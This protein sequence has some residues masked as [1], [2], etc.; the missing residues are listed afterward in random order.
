M[1]QNGG[2]TS[3]VSIAGG[4]FGGFFGGVVLTSIIAVLILVLIM[5]STKKRI[6]GKENKNDHIYT[7]TDVDLQ[8]N[9]AYDSTMTRTNSEREIVYEKCV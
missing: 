2:R 1:P 9:P 5:R 4:V 8:Q 3:G 7:S 6:S